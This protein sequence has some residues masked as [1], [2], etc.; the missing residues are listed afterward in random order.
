MHRPITYARAKQECLDYQAPKEIL[1]H[2]GSNMS[3]VRKLTGAYWSTQDEIY[4]LRR[5]EQVDP[6]QLLAAYNG[7]RLRM[8]WGNMDGDQIRFEARKLAK[9]VLME[10]GPRLSSRIPDEWPWAKKLAREVAS[11]E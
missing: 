9:Q 2:E 8:E 6:L 1:F 3:E 7:T 11:G 10:N 5:Y 4:R